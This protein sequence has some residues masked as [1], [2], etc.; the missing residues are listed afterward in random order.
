VTAN[1]FPGALRQKPG[2]WNPLGRVKFMFPNRLAIY[3]HDTSERH[4]FKRRVRLF[5]SGC[6]RVERPF[7]LAYY[8]LEPQGWTEKEL[9]TA[10]NQR[11]PRKVSL[12]EPLPI[13]ILYWTAWVDDAG[14]MQFRPDYYQRDQDMQTALE[15]WRYRS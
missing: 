3:L 4:L 8:L 10:M 5:S 2:P 13:R 12:R 15:L 14:V 9:E 7:E 1:N 11:K 6:I